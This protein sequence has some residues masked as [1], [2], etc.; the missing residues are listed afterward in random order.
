MVYN[1]MDIPCD[2]MVLLNPLPINEIG[3]REYQTIIGDGKRVLW[4]SW[5]DTWTANEIGW[6][7]HAAESIQKDGAQWN[8]QAKQEKLV[9]LT[10]SIIVNS[11]HVSFSSWVKAYKRS[12]KPIVDRAVIMQKQR[13]NMQKTQVSP[14]T[15][16][17]D[18]QFAHI[19]VQ[20]AIQHAKFYMDV[21]E[22]MGPE[23]AFLK[24]TMYQSMDESQE[25]SL[26]K[27]SGDPAVDPDTEDKGP[28]S[29]HLQ[30]LRPERGH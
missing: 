27:D 29:H 10:I 25:E 1:W 8:S 12:K 30:S 14:H 6:A 20:K 22:A 7:R 17:S 26:N 11:I 28:I 19:T 23:Q 16:F 18:N 24:E 21:P 9:A 15:C 13:R 2:S 3:M 5:G 4:P